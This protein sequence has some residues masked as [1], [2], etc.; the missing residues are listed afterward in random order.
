[1]ILQSQMF[2]IPTPVWCGLNE[3]PYA[4]LRNDSPR[5]KRSSV[6]EHLLFTQRVPG[7]NPGV[8]ALDRK[9]VR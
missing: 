2:G 5:P 6:A 9:S 1:M 8:L 3:V 7:S 4:G